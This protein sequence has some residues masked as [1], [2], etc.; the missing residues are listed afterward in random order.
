MGLHRQHDRRLRLPVPGKVCSAGKHSGSGVRTGNTA[1]ELSQD[2]YRSYVGVDISDAALAKAAKRTKENNRTDKNSFI[3]SDFL[4]YHPK[5]AFDIIL[6]RESLYHVPYGQVLELLAKYSKHLKSTGV[7]IVR[8]YLGDTRTGKIKFRVKRKLELIKSNFAIV[9]ERQYDTPGTPMVLSFGL[10]NK[11]EGP[12][13]ED[14]TGNCHKGAHI[15]N[16][17]LRFGLRRH[18]FCWMSCSRRSRGY[19][20]RS[21]VHA[22]V[23]LINAGN[24]PIIEADIEEIICSA[25]RSGR[26][27]VERC[28]RTRPSRRQPLIRLRRHAYQVDEALT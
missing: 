15:E 12:K 27:C 2:V 10:G 17:H 23:D 14:T 9:E 22:K 19:R 18:R 28:A 25:V 26:S 11:A 1:N 16:Q 20:R 21:P 3:V 7:F 8:L 5:Q 24:S 4:G 13:L 6:F